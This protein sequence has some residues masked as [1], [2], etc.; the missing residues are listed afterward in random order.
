MKIYLHTGSNLGDRAENLNRANHYIAQRIG[1]IIAVSPLYQ[2][3][4]WGVTQQADFY[5]QALCVETYHAP[6]TVLAEIHYIETSIFG[7]VRTQ[8]WAARIIDIDILFYENLILNTEN[9]TLP[10]PHLHLR[11]FVLLPMLDLAPDLEHPVFKQTL[12]QLHAV[13]P[14][15]LPAIRVSEPKLKP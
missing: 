15:I 11:N 12:K 6:E 9:L 3:A 4:A 1:T 2:T 10:H 13:C 7:R 14:D 5:N 8:K